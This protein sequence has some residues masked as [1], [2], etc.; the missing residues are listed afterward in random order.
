MQQSCRIQNKCIKKSVTFL[1]TN[2]EQ[3]EKEIR[4]SLPFTIVSTKL[5]YLRIN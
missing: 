1:Y 3:S 2:N 4:K 5:K